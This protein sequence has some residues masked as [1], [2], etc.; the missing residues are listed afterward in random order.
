MLNYYQPHL[1][2]FLRLKKNPDPVGLKSFYYH[3]FEDGLWDLLKNKFPS[4]RPVN[5]LVPDFYCSNV[6]DNIRLHGHKYIY[7]PLD[8]NFQISPSTFKKYLWLYKPDVIIIF[9]AC[10]IKSNLFS[11]HS[12]LT[13][14]PPDS[15]ILEDNVHVLTDPSDIELISPRHIVMDSLRKV[16]PIPGS[17]MWGT[18]SAL[19]FPQSQPQIF[20]A[21][22]LR[23]LT[24][25]IIFQLILK[26]G[27][28]TE[29]AGIVNW[30]HSYWLKIHDEIIG[31]SLF[32][33][34]GLP[35]LVPFIN[36]FNYKK[37]SCLKS[38]QM[39]MYRKFLK[40]IY[41]KNYF[42]EISI[43]EKNLGL[44]HVFPLGVAKIPDLNLEKYLHSRGIPVWFKF[45]DVPWSQKRG[46][47]FLPLGFH[48]N[49]KSIIH[50]TRV[51]KDWMRSNRKPIKS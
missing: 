50:L 5:I 48:I 40:S 47:L 41:D 10:G 42:Y 7:Y 14:L 51:L 2:P 45:T 3:S 17:R 22:Y 39:L 33:H 27:F 30:A 38:S 43:S 4:Q 29:S 21:Y 13:D 12:W 19:S 49:Q 1:R 44:M 6:L 9:N 16:S 46:V 18:A 31:D 36:R 32:S 11:D 15:W 24:Y 28:L 26:L 34:P 35:F 23:S 25:Y 20:S 37:V 8:K